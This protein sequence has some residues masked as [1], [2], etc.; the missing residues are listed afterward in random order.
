MN[1]P[2]TKI[3]IL[4]CVIVFLAVSVLTCVIFLTSRDDDTVNID[5]EMRNVI[6]NELLSLE[7]LLKEYNIINKEVSYYNDT[8]T[9]EYWL[10]DAVWDIENAIHINMGF[11]YEQLSCEV[12][13]FYQ[14]QTYTVN[15]SLG[16]TDMNSLTEKSKAGIETIF[17]V[18]NSFCKTTSFSSANVQKNYS[19]TYFN[20]NYENKKYSV[21]FDYHKNGIEEMCSYEIVNYLSEDKTEKE[22]YT[23]YCS[24]NADGELYPCQIAITYDRTATEDLVIAKGGDK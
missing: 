4:I 15:V 7:A 8:Q 17:S 11:T 20:N 16:M 19:E 9:G 2:N 21:E 3:L 10:D 5:L 12:C 1:K 22:K 13:L 14:N 24:K 18:L 6:E 23:Y